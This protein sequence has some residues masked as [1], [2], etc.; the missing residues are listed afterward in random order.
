MHI[1]YLSMGNF[2]N[3]LANT[4]FM[5]YS[6]SQLAKVTILCGLLAA[7]GTLK[8]CNPIESGGLPFV[9][10]II[11]VI[12]LSLFFIW[13]GF[14]IYAVSYNKSYTPLDQKSSRWIDSICYAIFIYWII[15]NIFPSAI[16]IWI[17]PIL[18]IIWLGSLIMILISRSSNQTM[19]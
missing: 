10:V 9:S 1:S 4:H 5:Q 6:W 2:L 12:T 7:I 18:I 11:L 15:F 14:F 8:D 16:G 3:R 19:K 13:V 17:L